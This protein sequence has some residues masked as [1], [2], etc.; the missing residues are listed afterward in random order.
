MFCNFKVRLCGKYQRP[1]K[2][3]FNFE[4]GNIK[5]YSAITFCQNLDWESLCIFFELLQQIF[6]FALGTPLFLMIILKRTP[7]VLSE[8]HNFDR[9]Y[10]RQNPKIND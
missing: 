8:E 3:R 6:A 7:G 9:E 10:P 2:F 1:P 5:I 4:S